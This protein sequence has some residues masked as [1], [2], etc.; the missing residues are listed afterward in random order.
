MRSVTTTIG[1]IRWFLLKTVAILLARHV[2]RLFKHGKMS[3]IKVKI[4]AHNAS[5]TMLVRSKKS[6]ILYLKQT[7]IIYL[8]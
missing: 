2:Q 1:A 7:A 3:T 4:H 6:L 8:R 5:G